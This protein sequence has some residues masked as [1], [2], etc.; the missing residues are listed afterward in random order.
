VPRLPRR[1]KDQV[2]TRGRGHGFFR[3]FCSQCL[4]LKSKYIMYLYLFLSRSGGNIFI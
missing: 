2:T 4:Y 1:R 3:Y